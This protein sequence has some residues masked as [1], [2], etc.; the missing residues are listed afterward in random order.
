M[1]YWSPYQ[2]ILYST[3]FSRILSGTG[4]NM[5]WIDDPSGNEETLKIMAK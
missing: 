3:F 2:N 4:E 5:I 1:K